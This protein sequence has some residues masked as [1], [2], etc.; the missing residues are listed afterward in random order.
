MLLMSIASNTDT[1]RGLALL[2]L[3]GTQSRNAPRELRGRFHYFSSFTGEEKQREGKNSHTQSNTSDRGGIQTRHSDCRIQ[4]LN[5]L[6]P[7]HVQL[8][9]SALWWNL[10]MFALIRVSYHL[11]LLRLCFVLLAATIISDVLWGPT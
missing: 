3:T 1:W 11:P 2:Q 6:T 5:H 4:A 9:S 8:S 10:Q 7:W